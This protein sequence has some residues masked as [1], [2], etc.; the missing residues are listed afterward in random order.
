L[1]NYRSTFEVHV[2]KALGGRPLASITRADLETLQERLMKKGHK[3]T[4]NRLKAY[5]GAFFTW[6]IDREFC[7]RDPTKNITPFPEKPRERVLDDGEFERFLAAVDKRIPSRASATVMSSPRRA[8]SV[9]G[10]ADA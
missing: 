8:S 2:A 9:S 10:V 5:L 1:I 3:A 6:A 4:A 7:Q